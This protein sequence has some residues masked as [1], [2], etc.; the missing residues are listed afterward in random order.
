MDKSTLSKE[1]IKSLRDAKLKEVRKALGVGRGRPQK[2]T[3]GGGF[4]RAEMNA[5]RDAL[6]SEVKKELKIKPQHKGVTRK[7]GRPKKRIFKK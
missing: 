2:A 6:V 4:T 1:Q 7:A 5:M 3:V